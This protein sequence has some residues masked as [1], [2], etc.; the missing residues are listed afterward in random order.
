MAA[1]VAQGRVPVEGPGSVSSRRGGHGT[2]QPRCRSRTVRGAERKS[3]GSPPGGSRRCHVVPAVEA[4]PQ[5]LPAAGPG[6]PG[7]AGLPAARQPRGWA[8]E[9]GFPWRLL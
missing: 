5:P 3:R 8:R 6:V 1:A 4:T 7:R 2:R 9:A